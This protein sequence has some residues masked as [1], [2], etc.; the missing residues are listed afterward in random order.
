MII[1]CYQKTKSVLGPHHIQLAAEGVK[2]AKDA[3]VCRS[4]WNLATHSGEFCA[5][6]MSYRH[7]IVK[8]GFALANE[9]PFTFAV[10]WV[11]DE[12]IA[13]ATEIYESGEK[14]LCI[15]ESDAF[16]LGQLVGD[17]VIQHFQPSTTNSNSSVLDACCH[18]DCEAFMQT[19]KSPQ[20][21]TFAGALSVSFEYI[22]F[23]CCDIARVNQPGCV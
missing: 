12:L 14:L 16:L 18:P 3:N 9:L 22:A 2:N 1:L 17:M 13:F 6:E 10:R 7:A 5:P 20:D 11:M 8:I 4:E 21:S 19:Y 23:G 15:E